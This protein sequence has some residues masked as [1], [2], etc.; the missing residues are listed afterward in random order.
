MLERNHSQK[1]S[2]HGAYSAVVLVIEDIV[3]SG[4]LCKPS[5]HLSGRKRFVIPPKVAS[6]IAAQEPVFSLLQSSPTHQTFN[7]IDR[8]SSSPLLFVI[9]P[10]RSWKSNRILPFSRSS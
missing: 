5:F 4:T 1:E 9:T 6:M 10:A 2:L 3:V 8:I 7:P